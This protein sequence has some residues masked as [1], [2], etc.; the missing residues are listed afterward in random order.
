VR[1]TILGSGSEGNALL[2]ETGKTRVL[3]DAGLSYRRLVKRFEAIGRTPPL[4]VSAVIV[5]HSHSDHGTH[6]STYATRFGCPVHA[7]EP[8]MK[9]LRLHASA[10]RT[11]LPVGQ[12]FH[13]G[14][15]AIHARKIPHDAPQVALRF[16]AKS[17]CVALVTDLGRV[18][19]GLA[20]FLDGC[21]SLLLESN[22]DPDM[23]AEGPYPEHLKRRVGGALGHLSNEQAS[24][25]L[26]E[27]P[28]A[29]S[30]LVLMHLSE[31]NNSPQLARCSAEAVLGHGPTRLHIAKQRHPMELGLSEEPQLQLGLY[32]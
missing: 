30:D 15:L 11:T 24:D 8:T 18:P 23:L 22:H 7:S 16:E 12:T 6:A 31:T 3:V 9:A 26:A 19:K 13:I 5:T 2:L 14:D 25:L 17:G 4:D 10:A 32:C 20:R 28:N 29:P 1:V 21:D 27:L